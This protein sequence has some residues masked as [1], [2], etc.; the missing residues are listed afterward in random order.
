MTLRYPIKA[1]TWL[2]A[3]LLAVGLASVALAAEP[4]VSSPA[5]GKMRNFTLLPEAKPVPE[6][7]FIDAMGQPHTLQEFQGRVVLLNFW[8]T[9][10]APCRREMPALDRLQAKLGGDDFMVLALSQ[11]RKGPP[12]VTAFLQKI[13]VANLA[14]YV[15]PTSR[16][17]RAFGAYGLPATVLLDRQGRALGR[18]VGPAEWDSDDAIKLFHHF[19]AKGKKAA[20]KS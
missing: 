12:V 13:A 1:A 2:L 10:C 5:R 3:T 8:A 15:D 20:D 11:D 17:A 14:V 7:G 19:I 16:S 4:T 18:M 9:W 6:I